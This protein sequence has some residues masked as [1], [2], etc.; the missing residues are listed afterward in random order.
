MVGV[1]GSAGGVIKTCAFVEGADRLLRVELD[2]G[3]GRLREI[4]S[5]IRASYPDP[6]ALVGKSVVVIANLAPRPR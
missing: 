2:L 5:G 4:F 3:E 1:R 6:S